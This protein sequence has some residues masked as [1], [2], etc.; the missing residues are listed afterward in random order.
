MQVPLET[1]RVRGCNLQWLD[2][3]CKFTRRNQPKLAYHWERMRGVQ[4]QQMEGRVGTNLQRQEAWQFT[5]TR[6]CGRRRGPT[7]RHNSF[8]LLKLRCGVIS[9]HNVAR[10]VEQRLPDHHFSNDAASAPNIHAKATCT[11]QT[12]TH[13]RA[14]AQAQALF[15]LFFLF[16]S[17][18]DSVVARY[19]PQQL[20]IQ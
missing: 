19:R 1:R 9:P 8:D 18:Q 12:R 16:E 10:N 20:A 13:T 2:I 11:N 14:F 4:A 3:A 6:P 15:V 7:N 5:M 17:K